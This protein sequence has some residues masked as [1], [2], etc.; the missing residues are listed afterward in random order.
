M[1]RRGKTTAASTPGSFAPHSRSEAEAALSTDTRLDD[2]LARY[3]V[4]ASDIPRDVHGRSIEELWSDTVTLA[5]APD[6]IPSFDA[7]NDY[8]DTPD[9]GRYRGGPHLVVLTPGDEETSYYHPESGVPDGSTLAIEVST[10]NGGGNRECWCDEG[11]E[12]HCLVQVIENLQ[13]HPK[14]LTDADDPWDR[15]YANFLFVAPEENV[16]R[17]MHEE[18]KR[19]TAQLA[20]RNTVEAV[21]QGKMP[22]WVVFPTNPDTASLMREAADKKQAAW[23]SAAALN[24]KFG[25]GNVTEGH[26][27]AVL[28]YVE[29]GGDVPDGR[30]RRVIEARAWRESFER[31]QEA[32]RRNDVLRARLEGETDPDVRA[33]L[34]AAIKPRADAELLA[35]RARLDDVIQNIHAERAKL[36]PLFEAERETEH[37]NQVET[38]LRSALRWPGAPETM[39]ARA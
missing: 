20:A 19:A 21:T 4:T 15:T 12:H 8:L 18:G 17:E 11:E 23:A 32:V 30:G 13:A 6:H 36:E 7:L 34:N 24:N 14:Y 33:A 35:A 9:Y 29:H 16:A 2:A 28:R 3:G 31:R 1:S 26:Y 22:P 27:E 37:W 5:D 38:T 25:V 10:R 39:P